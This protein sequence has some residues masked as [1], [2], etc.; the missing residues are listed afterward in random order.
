MKLQDWMRENQ[1]TSDML[2]KSSD[3]N[4]LYFMGRK[5]APMCNQNGDI[6]VIS[7][8]RSKSIDL[9]VYDISIGTMVRFIVRD[10]FYNWKVSGKSEVDLGIDFKGL[11]D[12]NKRI[13][14]CYCEGFPEDLVFGPYN[15]N[16]RAFT[17]DLPNQYT[18][19]VFFWL[20][21]RFLNVNTGWL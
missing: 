2:W 9:P 7:T 19:Y 18:V 21:T 11:I 14:A 5:I 13:S 3:Q 4:Q 12:E 16:K 8:H 10:N 1:I 20:I 17:V 6:E 15:D